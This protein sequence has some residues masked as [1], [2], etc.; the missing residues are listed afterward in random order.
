[1]SGLPVEHG[2]VSALDQVRLER[3]ARDREPCL[4]ALRARG[5][6]RSRRAGLARDGAES[7]GRPDPPSAASSPYAA[8]TVFCGRRSVWRARASPRPVARE[9]PRLASAWPAQLRGQQGRAPIRE[10]KGLG[11]RSIEY[12]NGSGTKDRYGRTKADGGQTGARTWRALRGLIWSRRR[13]PPA[14]TAP[15]RSRD[16][17]RRLELQR[18]GRQRGGSPRRT[19]A[20]PDALLP[21]PPGRSRASSL[22]RTC[23]QRWIS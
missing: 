23:S 4:P 19:D 21:D 22:E 18:H 6:R 11:H 8:R 3:R 2:R 16:D 12:S 7:V 13:S 10:V 5:P 15:K 20:A 9:R 17:G 14:R 1:M